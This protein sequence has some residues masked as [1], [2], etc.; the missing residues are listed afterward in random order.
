[1]LKGCTQRLLLGGLLLDQPDEELV[2]LRPVC[3]LD[4]SAVVSD[5]DVIR[6]VALL[7]PL[8][9]LEGVR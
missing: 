6:I 5:G 7:D 9:R 1:L 4:L 2:V 8:S 3:Q